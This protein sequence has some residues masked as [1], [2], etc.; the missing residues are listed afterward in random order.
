MSGEGSVELPDVE[1][2]SGSGMQTSTKKP[3]IKSKNC[4][5]LYHGSNVKGEIYPYY[6]IRSIR[7]SWRGIRVCTKVDS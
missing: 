1:S 2:G 6:Q 4:L 5:W 7:V 3:T